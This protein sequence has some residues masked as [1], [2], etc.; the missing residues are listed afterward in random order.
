[1]ASA[2]YGRVLKDPLDE[3]KAHFQDYP[4]AM[5]LFSDPSLHPFTNDVK[6]TS[7]G[8]TFVGR[9]LATPDTISASQFF[10][11]HRAHP[12]R[13]E[14]AE[15]PKGETL[16][17]LKIGSGV[18][19]HIDICHGGFVSLLLDE[20]TG[21]AADSVRPQDKSTMTAYLKVDYKRPVPTPTVVLCRAWV[22]RTEG[23]KM[24]TVGTVEDGEG[25]VYA[26]G[27]ALFIVIP[28]VTGQVKL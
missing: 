22:E 9:T 14:G 17:L 21:T 4:W 19:G 12:E 8:D 15:A 20:I 23:R 16:S 5:A 6:P 2:S 26:K 27:E 7:T 18:N 25:G 28:K 10:H 24:F 11:C 3:A 1:M 13:G